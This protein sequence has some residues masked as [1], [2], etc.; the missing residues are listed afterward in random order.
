MVN[1]KTSISKKVL[2]LVLAV[3]CTIAFTPAIAFTQS[4]HAANAAATGAGGLISDTATAQAAFGTAAVVTGT[5]SDMTVTINNNT[6]L[7]L[8]TPVVV[9]QN[10]K[11]TVTSNGQNATDVKV[12]GSFKLQS[13]ASLDIEGYTDV[14]PASS[15]AGTAAIDGTSM[16]AGNITVGEN[17]TVTGG[18]ATAATTNGGDAIVVAGSATA[19]TTTTG[20]V[21]VN[22]TVTGGTGTAN[23][24]YGVNLKGTGT[25]PAV[26]LSGSGTVSSVNPPESAWTA[27]TV[28]FSAEKSATNA[29]SATVSALVAG[30]VL[31]ASSEVKAGHGWRISFF[32]PRKQH[33]G[34]RISRY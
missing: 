23:A 30:N 32:V 25:Y 12:I 16:A 18:A 14:A 22:G 28:T 15:S 24:G 29:A 10:I 3:A 11:L 20:S 5:T 13:G 27:S 33:G 6:D 8:T 19:V 1:T 4:A 17:A 2:A 7:T 9:G 34:K 26:A 21:V 31:K